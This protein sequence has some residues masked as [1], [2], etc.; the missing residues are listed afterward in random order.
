MPSLRCGYVLHKGDAARGNT[1]PAYTELN[2]RALLPGTTFPGVFSHLATASL[3]DPKSQISSDTI[4]GMQTRI[5]EKTTVKKSVVGGHCKIGKNVRII[6]C[7]IMGHCEIEDG[8]V[9][10]VIC[11]QDKLIPDIHRAKLEN[12]VLGTN[13]KVGERAQLKDCET[14]PGSSIKADGMLVI[15]LSVLF[16]LSVCATIALLRNRVPNHFG[17]SFVF[18]GSA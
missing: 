5:G 18:F 15:T 2:R 13:T 10:A 16:G 14:E 17:F 12:C 6:G 4:I 9:T 7:I 11:C 1:L 8:Y 3:I